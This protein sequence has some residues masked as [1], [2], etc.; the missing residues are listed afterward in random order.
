MKHTEHVVLGTL[1]GLGSAV[2]YTVA[3]TFLR[4]VADCDPIWVSAIKAFPTMVFV[5]PWMLVLAWRGVKVFPDAKTLGVL[6]AAGLVGQL[7]G[8]VLFQW[9]LGI[10]G[11]ALTVPL[12]LGTIILG[13]GLL[14]RFFLNEPLTLRTLVSIAVLIVA[15]S[16]L[17]LGADDAHLSVVGSQGELGS[18]LDWWV[19]A[20]GVAAA[21]LS[22]LAYSVLGVVIRYG[23]T[24]RVSVSTTLFTISL[25][26][27]IS[28]GSWSFWR[29]GWDG[30]LS[31]DGHD[32]Q[33]MLLAGLFNAL[34]FL[35]ITKAFQLASVVYVNALNATQAAMAAVAGV[36]FFQEARSAELGLGVL[37][38]MV[39]LLL[40]KVGRRS[41]K[42]AG[43]PVEN[44]N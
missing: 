33:I 15:I 18:S 35:A 27:I 9:S 8:N 39:G 11:M 30:M 37:L 31:T 19:L 23:V 22:G 29:I 34:A 16:V 40:M 12:C 6:I 42:G 28:L 25:I 20:K 2:G 21:A 14:G 43:G 7:G 5:G 17:S 26:G 13:G 38:T 36:F 44:E 4:A 41:E 32:F 1:C 10:I 3:N 24:G